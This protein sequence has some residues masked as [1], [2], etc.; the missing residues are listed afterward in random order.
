MSLRASRVFTDLE[1]KVLLNPGM[2]IGLRGVCVSAEQ[3][4]ELLT[5]EEI[6]IEEEGEA[7]V[8]LDDGT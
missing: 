8:T 7:I 6:K 3:I 2:R 4:A 5:G 1:K